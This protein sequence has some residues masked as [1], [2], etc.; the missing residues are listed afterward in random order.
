MVLMHGVLVMPLA[1]KT[2]KTKK[3]EVVTPLEEVME[4]LVMQLVM[5]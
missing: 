1:L 2:G 4:P 5:G 3:V